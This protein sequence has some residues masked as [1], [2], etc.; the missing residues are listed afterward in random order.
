[1]L[2]VYK[3]TEEYY[4]S[5]SKRCEVC[6]NKQ[7]LN[8]DHDHKTGLVRGRLCT[9]CNIALACLKDNNKLIKNLLKYLN[10]NRPE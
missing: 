5:L 3:I 10:K 2:R 1:M 6:G 8:I 9:K 4:K 7:Q